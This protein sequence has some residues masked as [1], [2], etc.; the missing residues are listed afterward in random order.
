M[1]NNDDDVTMNV[2][3]TASVTVGKWKKDEVA[4]T[5]DIA[6]AD[7]MT[8]FPSKA[9]DAQ[10]LDDKKTLKHYGVKDGSSL[11][12]HVEGE[13]KEQEEE[14]KEKE[15]QDSAAKNKPKAKKRKS[16]SV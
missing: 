7:K 6:A 13:A 16:T 1:G 3:A 12:L 15:Q 9:D 10:E 11:Y 4:P 2:R 8:I 5:F 14:E